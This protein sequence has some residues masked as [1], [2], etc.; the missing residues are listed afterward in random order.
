MSFWRQTLRTDITALLVMLALI[1]PWPHPDGVWRG[2]L[3]YQEGFSGFGSVAVIMVAAMFVL[4]AAMVHTGA[5]ESVGGKLFRAC[6]HNEALFQIAILFTSTLFSMFMNDTAVVLIFMPLIVAVCKER[7]LSPSRYLMC[8]AYGSL[9]GGQWTLVGTRSN[10]IISDFLLEK[11]GNGIGFFDFTPIAAVVFVAAAAYFLLHGRK[12]LPNTGKFESAEE[13]LAREYLTEVL[14]TPQS[15]TVGKPLDQLKWWNRNDLTVMQIIRGEER[16]PATSWIKLEPGDVLIMQGSVPTIGDLLK[17]PDFQLKEELKINNQTLHSVDL[18]TVEALFS[19][20]SDYIGTT[21]E[22]MDFSHDYGFTVM[23]ISRHGKTIRERPMATPL[24]FG[25][26]L[27]LLGHVSGVKRLDRNPNLILLGQTHFPA[28]RRRKAAIIMLLLAGVLATAVTGVLSPAIS[29]PLAAIVAILVGC[30]KI[31]DAYESVNWPALVTVA[32]MIP[33]GLAFEK[34]GA[35]ADLA[36]HTV[37]LLQRLWPAGG[38]GRAAAVRHRVNPIHRERRRGDHPRALRFSNGQG[39]RRGSQAVSRRAGHLRVGGLLHAGGARKHDSRHGTGP[40]PV[41]A[42][43]ADR[44]RD[45]LSDLAHRHPAHPAGVAVWEMIQPR[46]N[47]DGKQFAFASGFHLHPALFSSL[48]TS[49]FL[50]KSPF[51]R[52]HLRF[53]SG[54]GDNRSSRASAASSPSWL[55]RVFKIK[56]TWWNRPPAGGFGRPAGNGWASIARKT[57]GFKKTHGGRNPARRRLN[58]PEAGSSI[59]KTCPSHWPAALLRLAV[60]L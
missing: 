1:L 27:L 38:A 12:L 46:M 42:L 26:S 34:T 31:K 53:Y 51:I 10:I 3:T 9:L 41:Q 20:N 48:K 2:I 15:A 33:F 44:Q 23:G 11:T 54:T 36:R 59:F 13:T 58:R 8:T 47:T 19:P 5:A 29:I 28:P 14:V 45:G 21:L 16:I 25:D 17:S 24:T 50:V 30:I 7:D 35:A 57:C 37:A 49:T 4:G 55:G 60:F 43:R 52:I 22:R 6:A 40:L 39:N 56:T 18:V 32:A